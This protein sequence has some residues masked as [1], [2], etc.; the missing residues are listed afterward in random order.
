MSLPEPRL[1]QASPGVLNP[2]MS[3]STLMKNR[4]GASGLSKSPLVS[5]GV[6]VY[7]GEPTIARA[8]DALVQQTYRNMEIIISDNAS[9]DNT[10]DICRDFAARDPRI[11]Y[12]RNDSNIGIIENFRKVCSAGKGDYFFWAAADDEWEPSFVE[13]IVAALERTPEA[14][15]GLCAVRRQYSDGELLAVLRF[16]SKKNGK[17]FSGIGRV[18]DLMH[19]STARRKKKYNVFVCGIF[20]GDLIRRAVQEYSFVPG[21]RPLV[22]SVMADHGFVFVDE[23]LMR[24]TVHRKH[25]EDRY[26]GDRYKKNKQAL[27][28]WGHYAHSFRF[29]F[30]SS[31]VSFQ[32]KCIV[33]PLALLNILLYLAYDRIK[34]SI[35]DRLPEG[36]ADALRGFK[37]RNMRS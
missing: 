32:S 16:P 27:G 28:G 2:R 8:L 25:F 4:A 9:Q 37:A 21:E 20:R 34:R 1:K 30:S 29:L 3:A 35:L 14:G 15:V 13:R 36:V 7:N 23:I 18:L 10:G 19:P 5:I 24:K 22:A 26:A 31:I 6:P 11:T 17:G 33:L 12:T